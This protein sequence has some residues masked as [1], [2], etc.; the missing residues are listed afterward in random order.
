[1]IFYTKPFSNEPYTSLRVSNYQNQTVKNDVKIRTFAKNSWQCSTPQI[2]VFYLLASLASKDGKADIGD[3][4][5][6]KIHSRL[7]AYLHFLHF[8]PFEPWVF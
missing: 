4:L 8:F 1:M 7:V 6:N 2:N 5:S 3:T